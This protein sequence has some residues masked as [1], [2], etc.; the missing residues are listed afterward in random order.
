MSANQY[1]QVTSIIKPQF[2][3]ANNN[4]IFSIGWPGSYGVVGGGAIGGGTYMTEPGD[5]GAPA[6][7]SVMWTTGTLSN[8]PL[9]AIISVLDVNFVT[10]EY[11]QYDYIDNIIA[12]LNQR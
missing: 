11:A 7:S 4:N 1:Y 5:P 12:S 6:Y 3:I 9:G 8:A 2:L 10:A